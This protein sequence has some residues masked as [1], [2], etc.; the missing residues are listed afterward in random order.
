[1]NWTEFKAAILPEVK[2]LLMSQTS[3]GFSWNGAIWHWND[4]DDIFDQKIDH[5]LKTNQLDP[6]F[7]SQILRCDPKNQ[8]EDLEPTE[9]IKMILQAIIDQIMNKFDYLFAA[10]QNQ[11]SAQAKITNFNHNNLLNE[12]DGRNEIAFLQ[13]I[14]ANNQQT[15]NQLQQ[16]FLQEWEQLQISDFYNQKLQNSAKGR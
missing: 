6:E 5:L 13:D 10:Y 12:D 3:Q 9:Q 14:L 4:E 11:L 1:M 16:R 8:F 7:Q 15:F 2:N